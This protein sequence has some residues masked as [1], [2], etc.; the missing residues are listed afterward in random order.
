MT[1]HCIDCEHFS[2][3]DAAGMAKQ[4]YG[5]CAQEPRKSAFESASF[6]RNCAKFEPVDADTADKRR[7]WLDW[8]RKRFIQEVIAR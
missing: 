8:E 3:R 6:P 7:A 2:L 1:V 5:R 4:G